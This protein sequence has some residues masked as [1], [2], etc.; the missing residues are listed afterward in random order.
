MG[1]TKQ[2]L[3]NPWPGKPLLKDENKITCNTAQYQ[4]C[5]TEKEPNNDHDHVH[6]HNFHH[7]QNRYDHN[8]DHN[9]H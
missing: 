7:N 6:H 3:S 5:E 1:Q 4:R 9:V 2:C 8:H